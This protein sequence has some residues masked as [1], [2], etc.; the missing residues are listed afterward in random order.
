MGEALLFKQYALPFWPLLVICLASTKWD[1]LLRLPGGRIVQQPAWRWY[2]GSSAA[3]VAMMALPFLLWSPMD[4]INDLTAWW[5]VEIHPIEGWNVWAFLL[6]WLGWDA[7]GALGDWLVAIDLGLAAVAM[8]AA[9]FIWGV[10]RPSRAL[11]AG[12]GAW[13]VL[14]LFARWT[15]YAYFAGVAPVILL[16]P[17]ADELAGGWS[18]VYDR[19][20]DK[21]PAG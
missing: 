1:V 21:P 8:A 19:W 13:F 5:S 20:R 16:I 6:E 3:F 11:V 10:A 2:A 7:Q 4:F 15:T 18:S 9:I 14:M 12:V 17:F